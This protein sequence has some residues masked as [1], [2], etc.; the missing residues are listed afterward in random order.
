MNGYILEVQQYHPDWACGRNEHVGYMNRVFK[1]RREACAYYDQYN[2]HMRSL[3]AHGTW[4][5]DWDPHTYLRYVVREHYN[6]C[7]TIPPFNLQDTPI[8]TV[9][10]TEHGRVVSAVY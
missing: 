5:S 6:E 9:K 7:L 8:I 1:T 3:N 4:R 2:P 10:L